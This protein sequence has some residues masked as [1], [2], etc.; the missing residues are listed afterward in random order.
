MARLCS[1]EKDYK[2]AVYQVQDI[3]LRRGYPVRMLNSWIKN[4]Y[5][6]KWQSRIL[7]EK[8]T[9]EEQEHLWLKSEDNPV[10]SKI[11]LPRIFSTMSEAL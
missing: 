9:D 1:Y 3:Y 2:T 5:K 11:D 8:E 6:S 7:R 4:N 10:W